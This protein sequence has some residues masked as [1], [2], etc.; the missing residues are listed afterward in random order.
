MK[1][2]LWVGIG[3]ALLLTITGCTDRSRTPEKAVSDRQ[4][5][6]L[7]RTESAAPEQESSSQTTGA[8]EASEDQAR[9]AESAEGKKY[10]AIT[11]KYTPITMEEI[12]QNKGE[13]LIYAGRLT[14]PYCRKLLPVFDPI[15]REKNLK[16]Y[17]LDTQDNT[18]FE[19]FAAE[20]GI[21]YVPA[22]IYLKDGEVTNL[23]IRDPYPRK[24]LEK[25]LENIS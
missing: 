8:S 7:N 12:N 11:S 16:V 22:L 13:K 3:L 15:A 23:R 20:H 25:A 21:E 2:K 18:E 19:D 10:L 1:N 4:S 17:Y 24:Q 14:C 9:L 5:S 6:A